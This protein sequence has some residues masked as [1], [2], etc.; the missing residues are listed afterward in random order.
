MH[1]DGGRKEHHIRRSKAIIAYDPFISERKL[2]AGLRL[3]ISKWK[4]IPM[5][6]APVHSK[7]SG[8][9]MMATI[10]QNEAVKNGFDDAIVLDHDGFL[11]EAITSNF[12]IKDNILYTPIADNF[13]NGI[14]QQIIINEVTYKLNLKVREN[15]FEVEDLSG[16]QAAFLT[17]TAIGVLKIASIYSHEYK[18][19]FEF[20]IADT[21]LE[22]IIYTYNKIVGA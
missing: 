19:S 17:G 1:G 12:F 10:I 13:L 16:S 14:T 3:E 11:T 5:S 21:L 4:K 9:Y 18:K 15:K 8:L 20:S 6:A 22:N 2:G 7:A